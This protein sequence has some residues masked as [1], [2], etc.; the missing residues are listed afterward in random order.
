MTVFICKS[1][2]FD[3]KFLPTPSQTQA[4]N[5]V[6][7]EDKGVSGVVWAFYSYGTE[8]HELETH[9][10]CRQFCYKL[11][12]RISHCTTVVISIYHKKNMHEALDG[13]VTVLF[14]FCWVPQLARLFDQVCFS[15]TQSNAENHFI[16]Q[17]LFV[18]QG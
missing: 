17:N 7:L 15:Q 3:I 1:L 4:L 10:S 14:W 5:Q 12:H 2:C 16:Q 11:K 9:V 18:S 6:L 8:L 13:N